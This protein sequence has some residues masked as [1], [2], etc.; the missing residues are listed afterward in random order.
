MRVSLWR[1]GKFQFLYGIILTILCFQQP[2][3]FN[4]I[5]IPIWNYFNDAV[6]HLKMPRNNISIPIWNYFNFDEISISSNRSVISIPIWNYFNLALFNN[7]SN[8][9]PLFQFLYGIILTYSAWQAFTQI[10]WISIPIWNY[11]NLLC[12][13]ICRSLLSISIPIWNYF[14]M[15]VTG[16]MKF[17]VQISIPIL[18]YFNEISLM[19]SFFSDLNFNSYMELF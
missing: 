3:P 8:N 5:S 18:N 14:N 2:E 13:C 15:Y 17:N 19:A 10:S 6:I 11:F 9:I 7:D 12:F 1:W 4:K 16:D